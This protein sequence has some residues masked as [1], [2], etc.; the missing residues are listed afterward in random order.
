[1]S[2]TEAGFQTTASMTAAEAPR[3]GLI[4]KR[5][6]DLTTALLLLLVFLPLLVLIALAVR[7]ESPG[8]A[9]FRQRRTGK[10]GRPFVVLKFRSMRAMEDGETV[11]QACRRD[12]RVTRVGA[13]LRRS[14]L[15]EL[16]QL[17]N[18]VRGDMSLIGPRPHALA[19]D[20]EL[21][22]QAPLYRH[23]FRM[24]PGLTGLA[25]VSGLRGEIRSRDSLEKRVAA[26][27]E[28]VE[29][30]SLWLDAQIAARTLPHLLV[31]KAAY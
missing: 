21:A 7:A 20:A 30:W 25:Q 16:P 2:S 6:L 10:D 19:H 9:L 17:L 28:Y 23:R 29:G 11:R 8:P 27:L 3:A 5:G 13:F 12:G 24:R 18:V 15:D 31:S 26:D 14:S 4:V 22:Q 1:M